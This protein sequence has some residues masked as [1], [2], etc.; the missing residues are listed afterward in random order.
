MLSWSNNILIFNVLIYQHTTFHFSTFYNSFDSVNMD[1][2]GL[3]LLIADLK[4][5]RTEF[6][7]NM[8]EEYQINDIELNKFRDALL[9]L[10]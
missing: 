2:G 1:G 3:A 7:K 9:N 6:E 4:Q 10:K 5:N 8:K